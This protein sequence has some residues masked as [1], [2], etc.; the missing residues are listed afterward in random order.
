MSCIAAITVSGCRY[1]FLTETATNVVRVVARCATTNGGMWTGL[2]SDL[3]QRS[4]SSRTVHM[5]VGGKVAL[6]RS[7][8]S[9]YSVHAL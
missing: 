8:M 7:E 3:A 6:P 4:H 1:M 2:V 9:V 5:L